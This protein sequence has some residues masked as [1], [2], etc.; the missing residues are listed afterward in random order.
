METGLKDT[1]DIWT[2]YYRY[3]K[4]YERGGPWVYVEDNIATTV[5]SKA[6]LRDIIAGQHITDDAEIISLRRSYR[7]GTIASCGGGR[8]VPAKV[9]R[10]EAL[11]A[12]ENQD[13]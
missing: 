12:E 1:I 13:G 4:N 10:A 7:S 5:T 3:R 6:K 11:R 9:A 8:V 2:L